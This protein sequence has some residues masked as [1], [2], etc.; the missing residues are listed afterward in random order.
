MLVVGTTATIKELPD[1]LLVTGKQFIKAIS[2]E[3]TLLVLIAEPEYPLSLRRN[4]V[5][6]KTSIRRA[7]DDKTIGTPDSVAW[8]RRIKKLRKQDRA[9]RDV[10]TQ[11]RS[12][13]G[14]LNIVG[15]ISHTL[16][17]TATD[18]SVEELKKLV[19][20]TQVRQNQ[21]I[22]RLNGVL[23]VINHTYDG[24]EENR[25][26]LNELT[27]F[28]NETVEA[29]NGLAKG[30]ETSEVKWSQLTAVVNIE[31]SLQ[32]MEQC[33]HE[34]LHLSHKYVLQ[35][36][37]LEA[38]RLND[39]LL[40]PKQLKDVLAQETK[41]D[42]VPIQPLQWYYEY[43][44][45]EPLW[46][47][48]TL[49]YRVRLPLVE[50]TDYLLYQFHSWPVPF[51]ESGYSAQIEVQSVMGLDTESGYIF[52][53]SRCYGQ[54]P[55]VCRLG[56]KTHHRHMKCERAIITGGSN[57]DDCIAKI[58]LE[59]K[60]SK[61]TEITPGEF[62][63]VTWGEYVQKRC[64]G[65]EPARQKLQAG[66]YTIKMIDQCVYAGEDWQVTPLKEFKGRLSVL[67]L[68]I[69]VPE[70]NLVEKV[71]H[72]R[73]IKKLE[74]FGKSTLDPIVRVTLKP[75]PE[76]SDLGI[77]S[78]SSDKIYE[79][80]PVFNCIVLMSMVTG[81]LIIIIRRM[82]KARGTKQ[83]LFK[84]QPSRPLDVTVP[85]TSEMPLE[86]M[87]ETQGVEEAE[88]NLMQCQPPVFHFKKLHPKLDEAG[89]SI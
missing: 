17:G 22:H 80:L 16:F 74:N 82:R 25:N 53:P 56:V 63:L 5:R 2:T 12:K 3:Y 66:V 71:N 42:I 46:D 68:K 84:S 10:H 89:A 9:A 52:K 23:S 6:L 81:I 41:Q 75:L 87:Q 83:K 4:I 37:S 86:N 31:R 48:D 40:T 29:V 33:H 69:D 18:K 7:V 58:K 64:P 44:T 34:Y 14:I 19:S 50:S 47:T 78:F 45:V 32:L 60:F 30:I 67:T 57:K 24:I 39:F 13:R 36:T 49:M 55:Q 43:A 35:R 26:R 21:V 28:V 79:Y 72:S 76:E 51:N 85:L 38:G 70:I 65:S 20:T 62:I 77:N 59:N 11:D 54:K 73:T 61:L 27:D 15:E 88:V 1:G 8:L